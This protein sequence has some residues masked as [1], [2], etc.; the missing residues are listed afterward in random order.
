MLEYSHFY[1][2]LS[3]DV[4]QVSIVTAVLNWKFNETQYSKVKI[5]DGNIMFFPLLHVHRTL[6][7]CVFAN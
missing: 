3:S 4:E 2:I 6:S 5:C 1:V 7:I